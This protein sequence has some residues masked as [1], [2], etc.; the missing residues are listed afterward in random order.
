MDFMNREITGIFSATEKGFGFISVEGEEQDYFVKAEDTLDA[1][2]NDMVKALVYPYSNGERPEACIIKVLERGFTDLVGEFEAVNNY[3]FV[4]P[5]TRKFG[6][7]IYIP[8]GETL[9][10]VDGHKVVVH[11]DDYGSTCKKPSGHITEILGHKNDPGVDILS[12]VKAFELPEEFPVS[13]LEEA[14]H[15]N[16]PVRQ[17]DIEGRS[18]FR[19]R[20]TITIDGIDTKDIDDA[21]S[22][23]KT[24]DGYELGVHIADVSHY[25]TADSALDQ[26]A[27]KRGTSVYLANSVIPMLPHILSNGICSLN[28]G[29][30]RLALSC[31]MYIDNQGSVYDHKIVE[32]VIRSD[33]RM[34]Y[35]DVNDIIFFKDNDLRIKYDDIVDM[36]DNMYELSK[37]LRKKRLLRGSIDFD[38]PES[39][40][41]YDQD[42][43]VVDIMP[44]ERN[45]ATMLIE[46]FMLLANETVAEDFYNRGVPFLYR[47]HEVPAGEK[48]ENLSRIMKSFGYTFKGRNG[49]IH[50]KE[51]QKLLSRVAGSE[52]EDIISRLALRSMQQARYSA[53]NEG[54]FGLASDYYCHFT[55]PIRRYPDL[56]IHRMIKACLHNNADEALL[57][58]YENIG[59][60][61]A[62]TTSRLERRAVEAE[63]AVDRLKKAQYMQGHIGDYYT[64]VISGITSNCIFVELK[65]TVE[66]LVQVRYLP[67]DHYSFD[68]EN[69]ELIGRNSNRHFRLGDRVSVIVYDVDEHNNTVELKIV[70]KHSKRSKMSRQKEKAKRAIRSKRKK[71]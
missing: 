39:K 10:A 1:Y 68:R 54:H 20:L 33:H 47:I 22:L 50:P 36:L 42:G 64:G 24:D 70:E 66:G 57:L 27:Y 4:I 38:L 61:V 32:S 62:K 60:E 13:A 49:Q 2:H 58:H 46:D 29:E 12:V 65:N 52:N 55:S 7:D 17:C 30:D 3:G 11:I 6:C 63:R 8:A 5:D 31:I 51:I 19:D 21:I 56:Y 67:R 28:E 34:N 45:A 9:K 69:Y 53:C 71:R 41:V 48:M 35:T 23:N 26:E 43:L 18:D 15:V 25:V 40:F 37:L 44:Y 16:T 59:D 14:D